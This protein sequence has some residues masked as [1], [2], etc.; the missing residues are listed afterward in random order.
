MPEF[1]LFEYY[2]KMCDRNIILD[3][4]GAVSQDILVG[5]AEMIRSKFSREVERNSTVKK[6]FSV[7][8]EMAQNIARY[9]AERVSLDHRQSDVGAGIIVVTETN[10]TYTITSGNLI[11]KDKIPSLIEHCN[12]INILSPA[13]L[14]QF[15]KQQI[16]TVR[17]KGQ[18]GGRIGLIEMVR[19]SG[20]PIAFD[21]ASVDAT[22]SFLVFSVKI[23]EENE[24]GQSPN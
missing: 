14:K 8:I 21:I 13:E 23:Q 10:K 6:I 2:K 12:K 18:K 17:E 7:F 19:K 4:Q 1:E 15:Y 11:E 16:K 20:G 5:M 22:H 3:F 24:H 9:S